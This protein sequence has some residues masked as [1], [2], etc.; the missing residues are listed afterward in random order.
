MWNDDSN[1]F[2]HSSNCWSSTNWGNLRPYPKNNTKSNFTFSCASYNTYIKDHYASINNVSGPVGEEHIT[3]LTYWISYYVFF[4]NSLQVAKKFI[5]M[6]TQLHERRKVC[7]NKLILCGLYESLEIASRDLT[8]QA[9][10]ED[11]I[12]LLISGPIWLLH[13]WLN[14]TFEPS[15]KANA[16]HGPKRRVEGLRLVKI[17]LDDGNLISKEAFETYLYMFYDC[18]KFDSNMEPF[19]S[20]NHGPD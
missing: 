3:F 10:H 12:P 4:S 19:F 18:K 8:A 20:R 14:A 5:P 16:A 15:L 13:L 11:E 17:M 9:D 1:V 7:F 2:L 6:A